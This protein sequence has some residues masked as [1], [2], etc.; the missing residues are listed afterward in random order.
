MKL[1]RKIIIFIAILSFSFSIKGQTYTY[2]SYSENLFL[3]NYKKVANILL[4]LRKKSNSI[5]VHFAFAD[6]YYIMYETSGGLEIYNSLCKKEADQ[7]IKKLSKKKDLTDDE[8]FYLVSA[9]AIVL[10]IQLERKHFL[11]VA[12]EFKSIMKQL[13]YAKNN[14]TNTRLK[15]VAGMYNYHIVQ[16]GLDHPIVSPILLLFPSGNKKTGI[17]L[18]KQCT[19]TNDNY[20]KIS[21][22]IFLSNIYSNN[23]NDFQKAQYYHLQL[24]KRYPA[25]VHWLKN[26]IFTLRKFKK[27]EEAKIQKERLVKLVNNNHQLT[28]SQIKY[29]KSI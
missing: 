1:L 9:K 12:K 20:S 23:E 4:H 10:K 3:G 8:V 22:L 14:H 17:S 21:A 24:I 26:Y 13:V 15:L 2:S 18:L 25:N 11:K 5:K 16:A 29:L 7:I 27:F 6:F 28:N 19:R